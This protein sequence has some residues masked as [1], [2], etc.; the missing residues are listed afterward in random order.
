VQLR[1]IPTS[2]DAVVVTS[3]GQTA[4]QRALGTA[5]QTVQGKEIAETQRENFINSLQGRIAG[6]EV[7]ST[8]GVPGASTSIVIRGV[9][10]ISSSNQPLMIIDGLPMDN[11][12]LNTGVLASDAPGSLTAFSNRGIDFTNRAADLNP[13]DIESLT[14]LKGPEAAALYGIDAANGAIVITTKRGR[15]GG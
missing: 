8:S 4:E 12:T 1:L 3:L 6:V 11:K 13:D 9:S 15:A 14:V 7:T 10:S 2:L 5:Q